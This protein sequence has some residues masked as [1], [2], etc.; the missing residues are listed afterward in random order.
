MHETYYDTPVFAQTQVH[1]HFFYI[2]N[3]I[4]WILDIFRESYADGDNELTS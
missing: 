2:Y 3:S 1:S 4:G